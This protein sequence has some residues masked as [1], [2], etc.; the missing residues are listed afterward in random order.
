MLTITFTVSAKKNGRLDKRGWQL[1]GYNYVM[2]NSDTPAY[3][4]ST[5]PLYAD[6]PFFPGAAW[7]A[8]ARHLSRQHLAQLF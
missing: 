8:S 6:I 4:S 5:D 2:W 3:D 1:G 7:R